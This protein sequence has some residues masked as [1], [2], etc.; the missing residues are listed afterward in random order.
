[1]ITPWQKILGQ[2]Q[3]GNTSSILTSFTIQIRDIIDA[4]W[5]ADNVVWI[6]PSQLE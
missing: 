6:R 3:F 1:M 2:T 4:A 5:F